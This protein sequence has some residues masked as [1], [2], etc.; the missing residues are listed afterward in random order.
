MTADYN[1]AQFED[2]RCKCVCPSSSLD[3]KPNVTVK[4]IPAEDCDCGLV[5]LRNETE[6]LRYESISIQEDEQ[7]SHLTQDSVRMES[8]VHRGASSW[9]A[10]FGMAQKRWKKKVQKQRE[11]IFENQ[12]ILS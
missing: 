2:V 12:T 3:S 5:T 11:D 7:A 1:L 8:S 4:N 6:C 10:R 9:L